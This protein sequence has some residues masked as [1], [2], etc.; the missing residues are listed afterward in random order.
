M[1]FNFYSAY[2]HSR[3]VD[4]ATNYPHPVSLKKSPRPVPGGVT[5]EPRLSAAVDGAE[6]LGA[7]QGA[8]GNPNPPC[9]ASQKVFSPSVPLLQ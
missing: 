4:V 7:Y 6:D 1:V 3:A 2:T 5:T 8:L 9:R